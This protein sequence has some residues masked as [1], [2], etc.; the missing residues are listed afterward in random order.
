MVAV[1]AAILCLYMGDA[2]AKSPECTVPPHDRWRWGG[3]TLV[4]VITVVL[5]ISFLAC[6]AVPRLNLGAL[7]GARA[8]AV[9]RRI[10]TD[11]RR[12]RSQAILE[13]ARNPAGYALVMSGAGSYDGYQI[14]DRRN[15]AVVAEHAIPA[16]VQ[17]HGGPRF[18]FEP[19]GNLSAASGAQLTVAT[20][21]KTYSL[22]IV[23]ATGAV[24]LDH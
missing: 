1:R 22:R 18:E 21:G 11:L 4:E 6:V 14:V 2:A 5:I 12:T 24:S 20:E 13:A 3:H 19:L 10:V 8:D 17:C 23:R 15:G 7:S 9:V 16:D